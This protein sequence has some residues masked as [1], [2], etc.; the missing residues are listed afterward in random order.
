MAS[1]W[2]EFE[3]RERRISDA[4]EHSL[5]TSHF[6]IDARKFVAQPLYAKPT[7]GAHCAERN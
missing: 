1:H 6:T 2:I 4:L 7:R 5:S 3:L